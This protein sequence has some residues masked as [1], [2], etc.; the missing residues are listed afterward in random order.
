MSYDKTVSNQTVKFE[1]EKSYLHCRLDYLN[2]CE[3]YNQAG[4]E[5]TFLQFIQDEMY[6][7]DTCTVESIEPVQYVGGVDVSTGV[8]SSIGLIYSGDHIGFASNVDSANGYY[9]TTS[10]NNYPDDMTISGNLIING[11]LTVNGD[12]DI[13]NS[14]I[15]GSFSSSPVSTSHKPNPPIEIPKVEP[16]EDPIDNRFDILDL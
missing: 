4:F 15:N 13:S 12:S 6:Y 1:D 3:D 10:T 5:P 11:N 8:D 2:Y 14:I 16:P 9:T 7:S